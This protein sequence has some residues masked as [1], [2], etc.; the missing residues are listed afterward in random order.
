MQS[1]NLV[2]TLVLFVLS[3]CA[4]SVQSEDGGTAAPTQTSTSRGS[5]SP[6]AERICEN[7]LV[8]A[9]KSKLVGFFGGQFPISNLEGPATV[10]F[11]ALP[12]GEDKGNLSL[13]RVEY[14]D[15]Y[16]IT[17]SEFDS[18]HLIQG[19]YKENEETKKLEID[20]ILADA[21]G[22]VGIKGQST[23]NQ[24]TLTIKFANLGSF[25]DELKK[26][27]EQLAEEC[28]A[29]TKNVA[30]C[31]GYN[32]PTLQWWNDP[33]FMNQFTNDYKINDGKTRLQNGT[34]LGTFTLNRDEF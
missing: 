15:D 2:L 4:Q 18:S 16:G 29:G 33:N 5:S 32:F 3:A 26:Q 28:R 30:Q 20:Y 19:I 22:Y 24:I 8:G 12:N 34:T 13:F 27:A 1:K 14:E 11:E 21:Y 10:C 31:L 17:Y 23:T 25:E 9:T 6:T 7:I